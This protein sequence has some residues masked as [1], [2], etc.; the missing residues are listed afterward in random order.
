MSTAVSAQHP[1]RPAVRAGQFVFVSGALSVDR[2]YVPVPGR[3]EALDAAADRMLERLATA[4][5]GLDDVVKLTYFV[6]D[7]SLRE[8]ANRQ[9]E[10]LFAVARPA[11]TF[12]EVS[13]LP[14]GATV[15]IDAIACLTAE[16]GAVGE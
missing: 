4:G 6:T 11:R 15:E 2:D 13:A 3:V 9:F 16:P 1:Y 8:E 10:R 7:L 5:G 14:Y 12:V